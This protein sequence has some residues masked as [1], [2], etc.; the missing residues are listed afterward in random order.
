MNAI[1]LVGGQSQRFGRD[2]LA[3]KIG[4][5][6]LIE[7]VLVRLAEIS[8]RILLVG[9]NMGLDL[10]PLK[11]SRAQWI[12]DIYPGKGT[13]G[14]LYTGL[15]A[16]DTEHNIAVGGDMPFLNTELLSYMLSLAPGFQAVVPRLGGYLEPLHAVYSKGCLEAI[17][18]ALEQNRL[19]I[20]DLI[21]TLRVRY[22]EEEEVN[23][24]DPEHLSL[25]NI[26][27]RADLERARLLVGGKARPEAEAMP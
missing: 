3:Q 4:G 27:T 18:G 22:V 10:P 7:H 14:G 2:K 9:S 8:P 19:K 6:R 12:D 20:A 21:P 25:L 11:Q 5:L 17:K 15:L 13:L 26:N 23:L 1:V 24:Y 16:S